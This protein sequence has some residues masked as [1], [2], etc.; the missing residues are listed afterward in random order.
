[1]QFVLLNAWIYWVRQRIT[2][3]NIQQQLFYNGNVWT[4]KVQ[5]SVWFSL[6]CNTVSHTITNMKLFFPA[7]RCFVNVFI[8][9]ICIIVQWNIR[10]KFL[11]GFLTGLYGQS[12]RCACVR[13]GRSALR[14]HSVN[15]LHQSRLGMIIVTEW[16]QTG[17]HG[18]EVV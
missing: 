4:P 8:M 7:M 15:K 16:I 12:H 13:V 18:F 10:R 2:W 5:A 1:M 17:S 14:A 6:L 3:T 9:L 11:T